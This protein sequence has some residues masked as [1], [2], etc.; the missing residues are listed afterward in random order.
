MDDSAAAPQDLEAL[1]GG[2]VCAVLPHTS[3]RITDDSESVL[4]L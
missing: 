2:G 4:V 3:C 1:A